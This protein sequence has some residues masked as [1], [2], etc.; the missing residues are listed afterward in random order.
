ML[1]CIGLHENGT[2]DHISCKSAG[3][4]EG[5]FS[6]HEAFLSENAASWNLIT[7]PIRSL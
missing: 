3:E 7:D 5:A 4:A 1:S 2:A 6:G